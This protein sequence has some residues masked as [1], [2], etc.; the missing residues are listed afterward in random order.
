LVEDLVRDAWD[1]AGV[2]RLQGDHRQ[3]LDPHG[4]SMGRG[5]LA[6]A[7]LSSVCALTAHAV[8]SAALVVCYKSYVVGRMSHG[9]LL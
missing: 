7:G 2:S 8:R 1:D 6:E 3:P 5:G 4:P 9:G